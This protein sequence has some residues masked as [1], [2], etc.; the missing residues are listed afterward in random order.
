MSDTNI[1]KVCSAKLSNTF[2]IKEMM[3]G[4]REDFEYAQCSECRTIQIINVPVTIE[5]YYPDYYYSFK[6]VIPKLSPLPFFKKLFNGYRIK[7]KYRKERYEIFRHLKPLMIR[8]SQKILDIGCGRGALICQMFNY[9]FTNVEGIDKYIDKEYNYNYGVN[10]YKK[11]LSE[12]KANSYDLLMMHHVFEHMDN[13]YEELAKCNKLLKQKGHLII[14]IPV[15]AKAWEIYQQ[16]WIQLDA[17]RHFFLHTT[18]SMRL[19]AEKT[20]FSID[21]IV[22]DSNGFQFWGSELYKRDIGLVDENTKEYRRGED[23]F[24]DKELNAFDLKA[25]ELNRTGQGD[26]AIFYLSKK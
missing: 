9:G 14:R 6:Q 24:S 16:D 7:K 22:Y 10:V 13:P 25:E 15:V 3:L 17:P 26:Q 20:G 12:L 23:F 1:C 21:N 4:L 11:D 5:K 18:E 8:P 19:L 2:K